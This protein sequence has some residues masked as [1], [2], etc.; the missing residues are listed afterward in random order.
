MRCLSSQAILRGVPVISM[1]SA[2]PVW[3]VSCHDFS[4]L[5]DAVNGSACRDS[6]K[7]WTFN[8]ANTMWSLEDIESGRAFEYLLKYSKTLS[9]INVEVHKKS[10]RHSG[11]EIIRKFE[12]EAI[13]EPQKGEEQEEQHQQVESSIEHHEDNGMEMAG[14]ASQESTGSS[15]ESKEPETEPEPEPELISARDDNSASQ[16][17]QTAHDDDDRTVLPEAA[18]SS[19]DVG[20]L[21]DNINLTSVQQHLGRTNG[22]PADVIV[23]IKSTVSLVKNSTASVPLASN[24]TGNDGDSTSSGSGPL[25]PEQGLFYS[26]TLSKLQ[27]SAKITTQGGHS[28]APSETQ[29]GEPDD[30]VLEHV[31]FERLSSI[32]DVKVESHEAST[33]IVGQPWE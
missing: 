5:A 4:Y 7:Q 29:G 2:S 8:L 1:S 20:R 3:D 24:R 23:Q 15:I 21:L 33:P 9:N 14:Q 22:T 27:A 26:T 32:L 25:N 6:R 28:M 17:P 11:I 31:L 13:G 30:E 19:L 16:D 12:N 10:K 18:S